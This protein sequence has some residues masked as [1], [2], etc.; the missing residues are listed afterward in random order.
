[1][2]TL[3]GCLICED[4]R[5]AAPVV[6]V[7]FALQRPALPPESC[8]QVGL[9]KQGLHLVRFNGVLSTGREYQGSG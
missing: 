6:F 7:R 3:S 9:L 2:A 8:F 1:M 5:R 4:R